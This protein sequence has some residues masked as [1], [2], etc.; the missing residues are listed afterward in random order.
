M[1]VRTKV[2]ASFLIYL[3]RLKNS[4]QIFVRH[5]DAGIGFPVLEQ[6]II[7]WRPLLYQVVFQQQSVLFGIHHDVT[8]V[9]NLTNQNRR[10]AVFVL[11]REVGIDATFQILRL[12]H[13]D[14]RSRLV[15]ILIASGLF[16]QIKH[17]TSQIIVQFLL[18]L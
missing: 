15:E 6:N 5:H 4:R 16:W 2:R 18:F 13:I 12:A 9:A 8:D 7:A 10:L 11:L 14:D 1:A 3:P 17:D